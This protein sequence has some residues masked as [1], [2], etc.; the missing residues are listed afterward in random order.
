MTISV[1]E[2]GTAAISAADWVRLS[3]DQSFWKLV[4]AG[5]VGAESR[6]GGGWQLKGACYVGRAIVGGDVLE[7]SE[8][9]EGSFA[10]LLSLGAARALTTTPT[11][12][13]VTPD[14]HS[15]PL[16]IMFFIRAAR[17]YLSGHKLI[18]Y[19]GRRDKG[20]LV[21]GRLDIRG[22]ARLHAKGMRHQAAFVRTT[23]TADVPL[24]RAIYAAL[25]QVERISKAIPV[26]R[27]DLASAR[28]LSSILEECLPS[29]RSASKSALFEAAFEASERHGLDSPI[30]EVGSL[31]A[32]VL[33][34]AGFGGADVWD[35][36]IGRSWF[37]NLETQFETAVRSLVGKILGEAYRVE[38][39][40][41]R[42]PL[43]HPASGRYAANPDVVIRHVGQTAAIADAKYKDLSSW[44]S[45]ADV[46][47]LLCHASA[48][49]AK[50]A[51]LIFPS[52]TRFD[53]KYLGRSA[54]GCEVWSFGVTFDRLEEDLRLALSIARFS[55]DP[56]TPTISP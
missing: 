20:T 15:T 43:F 26:A 40:V 16:L 28:A 18:D 50:K 53:S 3:Q 36:T 4:N 48:Y 34:S 31:A 17:R 27:D 42:P 9:F 37:V 24:N 29:V 13:P 30:G 47:E 2:R 49:G 14:E 1:P 8:K 46:H 7:V 39:A 54:G 35:R 19:V 52:E 32:A 11:E 56:E 38:R 33:D 21:G 55:E 10:K 45:T 12:A 6:K 41:R 51:F 44:P 5:V 25:R 22:T 23:I